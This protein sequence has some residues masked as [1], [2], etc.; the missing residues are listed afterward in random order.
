MTNTWKMGEKGNFCPSRPDSG[1]LSR[2]ILAPNLCVSVRKTVTGT[3]GVVN[4]MT[5]HPASSFLP[6]TGINSRV[7][8]SKHPVPKLIRV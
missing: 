2:V 5:H 8:H 7:L 1:K 3:M 6:F 4:F